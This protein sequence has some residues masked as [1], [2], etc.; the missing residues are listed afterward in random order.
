MKAKLFILI[1]FILSLFS[2]EKEVELVVNS[3]TPELVIE[4]LLTADSHATVK[5]IKSKNYG[6]DN[7]YPPIAGAI[8]SISDHTGKSEVLELMSWGLYE[9]KE[10]YGIPGNTYYL[11]IIIEEKEYFSVA[12]MPY[13]VPIQELVIEDTSMGAFPKIS[14]NDPSETEN[15]YRAIL[16]INGKRMP[17]M[18]IMDDKDTNGKLNSNLVLFDRD[19]NNGKEILKGDQIRIEMQC[20]DKGTYTYFETLNRINSS[21]TNPTSNIMGGALGYFGVYISDTKEITANWK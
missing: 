15:Y 7:Y 11:K 17:N 8:V 9:S 5:I 12:T 14:Y 21:Q 10:I 13:A 19:Y 20:L 16:Y 4:A 2:C 1:I 6:E 3:S 18:G